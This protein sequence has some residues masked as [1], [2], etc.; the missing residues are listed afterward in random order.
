M[1]LLGLHKAFALFCIVLFLCSF[2]ASA[3]DSSSK[4]EEE[5]A[6][7]N[8]P[9]E[10]DLSLDASF[11]ELGSTQAQPASKSNTPITS[12]PATTSSKSKLDNALDAVK[13]DIV[14]KVHEID[15]EKQWVES[16]KK[17]ID[18]YE[19][20]ITRVEAN[21]SQLRDDVKRLYRKKKQIENLKLQNQLE[22]KLRDANS[23]LNTLQSALSHVKA[24]ADEF[25]KTRDEIMS[26]ITNINTQLSRLR[27]D[28]APAASA[29]PTTP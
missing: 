11:A 15:E 14:S 12:S 27:G 23:D 28:S 1:S 8:L 25:S 19:K 29:A 7:E 22:A 6:F 21:I 13:S 20:K 16:V 10:D 24:K 3:L 26:T 9:L 17:I 2:S 4:I 5:L 18:H